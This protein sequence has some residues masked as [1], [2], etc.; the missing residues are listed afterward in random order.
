MWSECR[1]RVGDE[2]ETCPVANV[3]ET[4]HALLWD[5]VVDHEA[6]EDLQI[7]TDSA[8]TAVLFVCSFL[9]R[10]YRHHLLSLML[11]N[12]LIQDPWGNSRLSK[13][14]SR[15]STLSNALSDLVIESS[16]DKVAQE[17]HDLG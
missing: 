7:Y 13:T 15:D 12:Q 9:A 5:L 6:K 4:G 11:R 8:R 3:P 16:L 17:V 10:M 1:E 14:W 2:L